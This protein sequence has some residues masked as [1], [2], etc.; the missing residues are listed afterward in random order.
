MG[1]LEQLGPTVDDVEEGRPERPWTDPRGATQRLD[2]ASR[3][4]D[5]NSVLSTS[6]AWLYQA[7][8][9]SES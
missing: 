7:Y 4:Y 1:V 6:L 2:R 9:A 5:E 8:F 3:S